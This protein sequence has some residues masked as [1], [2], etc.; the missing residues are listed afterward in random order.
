MIRSWGNAA[1]R[2]FAEDGKVTKFR[3]LD[4]DAALESIAILEAATSLKDISPLKSVGL[5]KLRGD[6]QGQWAMTVNG[7]WRVCFE[8]RGGD[9]FEVEIVDYH[10]G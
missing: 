6:R 3:G 2:R 7:P 1:T 8:F 4:A 9:A 10:R 5:H